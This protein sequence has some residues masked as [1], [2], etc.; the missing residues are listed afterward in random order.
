MAENLSK[1]KL[2]LDEKKGK[3]KLYKSWK[4]YAITL[5]IIGAGLGIGLGVGLGVNANNVEI[6][7]T[8][9]D[10]TNAIKKINYSTVT[11]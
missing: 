8:D 5:G 1:S 11:L 10:I 4:L 6:N 7:I 2:I 9:Q 3:K